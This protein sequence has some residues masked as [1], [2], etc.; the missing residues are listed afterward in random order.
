M[1]LGQAKLVLQRASKRA[2]R[3]NKHQ[4]SVLNKSFA[5][6][7]YPSKTTL[8]ELTLQTGLSRKQVYNWFSY[9]R[10]TTTK[11]KLQGDWKPMQMCFGIQNL[12][13]YV[14]K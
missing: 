9:R 5:A 11:G 10:S 7:C 12:K 1:H 8:K 2:P 3:L 13:M 6:H 14:C 4:V